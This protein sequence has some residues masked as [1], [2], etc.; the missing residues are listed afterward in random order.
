MSDQILIVEDEI[1]IAKILERRLSLEGYDVDVC[2]DGESALKYIFNDPPA[3][4][5]LD[6][7]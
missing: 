5:L 7:T 1:E 3:L 6:L 4:V 2:H